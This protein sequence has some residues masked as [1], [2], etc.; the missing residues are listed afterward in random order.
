M[1]QSLPEA[2]RAMWLSEILTAN[3]L[4]WRWREICET[5]EMTAAVI[6]AS[7]QAQIWLFDF[8]NTLAALE[9]Q[10][11]WTASRRDLERFLRAKGID[12]DL[13]REFPSRNLPLYDALLLRTLE[14]SRDARNLIRQASDIIESYE[15]QGVTDAAPL[16]GAIE[17]LLALSARGKRIAIVTSNS[18]RTVARWLTAHRLQVAAVVGRDSLLPLKPAPAMVSRALEL[19]GGAAAQTV[20]VG[21]SEAD[22]RAANSAHVGFLGIAAN[23]EARTG[24]KALDVSEIFD[25]P[26]DLARHFGLT[27]QVDG[28]PPT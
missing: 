13:F 18:A 10:V 3:S 9:K 26:A 5:K 8:D 15:L 19:I 22:V 2:V 23:L 25:S 7:A 27:G 20:L 1:P 17:L 24:L 12:D 14:L 21:D 6:D 16:S 28:R 11:D 4:V